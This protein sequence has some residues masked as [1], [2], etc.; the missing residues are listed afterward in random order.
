MQLEPG[1]VIIH[2]DTKDW[3]Q[4][5]QGYYGLT[6]ELLRIAQNAVEKSESGRAIFPLSIT[7]FDE[8][9]RNLN[10]SRRRRLASYMILTSK[11]WGILPAPTI[12]EPE[13]RNACRRVLG[14]PL[15]DLRSLAIGKGL[16]Q[17]VGAEPTLV[18]KKDAEKVL[19]DNLK[20]RFQEILEDPK[21]TTLL[22]LMEHGATRAYLNEQQRNSLNL[23]KRLEQIRLSDSGIKDNDL[24]RRVALA[25]YLTDTDPKMLEYLLSV[26]VDAKKFTQ[27]V[28]KDRKTITRFFQ[29]MP[30]SYCLFQLTQY[31]DMLKQRKIQPNDLN[32]I[33]SLSI[34]IPYSDIVVTER[35]WQ[36]AIAQTKLDKLYQT[37]V[38]KS[39]R[40]LGPILESI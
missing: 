24:R 6:P 22:F 8:T 9:V 10:P 5:A 11:G 20:K 39:V 36:T 32:D 17:I 25:K 35:M 26:N 14:L 2:L 12:I 38:L 3:I 21:G 7:H 33:M 29:F 1:A 13:I 28:L 15:H 30:T 40:E 37:T 23:V 27:T 19:P 4:L 34:A 31:R 18:Y 16:G